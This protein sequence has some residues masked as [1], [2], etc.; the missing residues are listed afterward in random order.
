MAHYELSTRPTALRRSKKG[1]VRLAT[2]LLLPMGAAACEV[3]HQEGSEGLPSVEEMAPLFT[4]VGGRELEFSGNVLQVTATVDPETYRMGGTT[5]LR[6]SPYI[7]LFSAGTQEALT[8]YPA[9]G[10]VRVLTRTPDGTLIASA[11]LRQGVLTS[12]TWRRALSISGLAR[13]EGSERPGRMRDLIRWG[14]DHTEFEYNSDLIPN[15]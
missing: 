15:P 1:W 5:W 4:F 9:L 3:G 6:A 2:I 8:E 14:E 11:L 13:S 7:F 12:V 10:G